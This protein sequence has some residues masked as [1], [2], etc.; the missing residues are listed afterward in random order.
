MIVIIFNNSCGPFNSLGCLG[1]AQECLL[2]V[3]WFLEELFALNEGNFHN[4]LL[5]GKLCRLDSIDIH[6]Y[7]DVICSEKYHCHFVESCVTESL[8]LLFIIFSQDGMTNI[9]LDRVL[10]LL[11]IDFI[12][13]IIIYLLMYIIYMDNC[14]IYFGAQPVDVFLEL[15]QTR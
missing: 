14:R 7:R 12:T 10:Y 8:S 2:S 6:L 9:Y 3:V 13:H 4:V 15:V 1:D 5:E 11:F